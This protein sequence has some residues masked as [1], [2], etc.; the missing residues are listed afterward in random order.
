MRAQHTPG[1]LTVSQTGELQHRIESDHTKV[2]GNWADIYVDFSGFF[3]S[4][5]PNVFAAAPELLA[6]LREL[7]ANPNDPRAHRIAL[8]AIAKANG[9][10]S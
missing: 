6:A 2:P 9:S 3:G 5:G 4:Y 7:Q 10:A 8:N 1:P